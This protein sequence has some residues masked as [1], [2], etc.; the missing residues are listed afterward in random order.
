[1]DY[2]P[3]GSSVHRILQARILEWVACPPP[4]YLPDSKNLTHVSCI[5][6]QFFVCLF[7]FVLFLPLALTGKPIGKE[8]FNDCLIEEL[9][10]HEVSLLLL[11]L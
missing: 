3:S 7:C 4:G 10:I 6:R 1:M 2:S 9:A 11:F 8:K 5:G